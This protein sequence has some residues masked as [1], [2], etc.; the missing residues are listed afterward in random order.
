MCSLGSSLKPVLEESEGL[1]PGGTGVTGYTQGEKAQR[2][3]EE[4]HPT[5]P[6]D[7]LPAQGREASGTKQH[8]LIL[9]GKGSGPH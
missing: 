4:E 8:T 2:D 1:K 9:A 3:G 7:M 5:P 6:I